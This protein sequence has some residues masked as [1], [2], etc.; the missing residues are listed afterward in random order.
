MRVHVFKN[1]SAQYGF[2]N[3]RTGAHLPARSGPWEYVRDLDLTPDDDLH[4]IKAGDI[5]DGIASN[6]HIVA[7]HGVTINEV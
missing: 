4:G 7:D 6:G 2:T 3:D 1:I 5:L